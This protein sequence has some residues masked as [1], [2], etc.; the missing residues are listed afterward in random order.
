MLILIILVDIVPQAMVEHKL[1]CRGEEKEAGSVGTLVQE[2]R[3]EAE[4]ISDD[5]EKGWW[6]YN[7]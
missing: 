6:C 7:M 3:R 4:L 5:V 2:I 1:L